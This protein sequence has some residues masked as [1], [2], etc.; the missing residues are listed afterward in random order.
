LQNPADILT[1]SKT[2]ET[3][4]P[5]AT[6]RPAPPIAAATKI[7]TIPQGAEPRWIILGDPAKALPV[8]KSWKPFKLSSQVRWNAVLMASSMKLL[9]RLPN[10]KSDE[11]FIDKQYWQSRL[12]GFSDR[13]HVVVHV[14]NSSYTRK[15]I[16]FFIGEDA[17]IK[18]VAKVPLTSAAG[19]AILNEA[20]V[21]RHLQAVDDLPRVL[22]DDTQR[23]V[24]AQTFLDGKA[25]SRK[26]TAGHVELL[27]S[28]ANDGATT[29]LSKFRP[30][31]VSALD[32]LDLPLDRLMLQRSVD[33]LDFDGELPE[34]VEHR[35]FAP[36]NIKRLP[37][38]RLTLLD[39][40]WAVEKSLP[41]QDMCRYFYI[42][43]VLFHGPGKV[44]ERLTGDPLVQKY[45][46]KF[47][48]PT[49]AL[50]GLTM[51]YLLRVLC[52]D[53]KNKDRSLTDYTLKQIRFLLESKSR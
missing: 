13:W 30:E 52:M 49:A 8:L 4:F 2:L 36:W 1:T 10:V 19:E 21:L 12:E 42:Q 26:F 48:I 24:A 53:W 25:V 50:H 37:D 14:G 5:P 44:W 32:A 15:A 39:W 3:A 29:R 38:G 34:F 41:W 18:A 33:F 17:S 40:E 45:V 35:D 47:E 7:S 31:I 51:Y 22:F 9:S 43:D 6:G 16:V 28:L 46:K 23:G 11:A 27:G 20:H